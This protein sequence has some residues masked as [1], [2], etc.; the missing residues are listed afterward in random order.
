MDEKLREALGKAIVVRPVPNEPERYFVCLQNLNGDVFPGG[1][2]YGDMLLAGNGAHW[3][4]GNTIEL[5]KAII[6][7]LVEVVTGAAAQ[8]AAPDLPEQAGEQGA[9]RCESLTDEDL[10]RIMEAFDPAYAAAWGSVKAVIEALHDSGFRVTR[11]AAPTAGKGPT[12]GQAAEILDDIL[13]NEACSC[14]IYPHPCPR[15][16]V[17][18]DEAREFL[19]SIGYQGYVEPDGAAAGKGDESGKP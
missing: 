8:P 3:N 17:T 9:L 4:M 6:E 18:L 7:L 11:L 15:C 2:H 1:G 13:I 19:V 14:A 12:I 10:T 5:R 16:K